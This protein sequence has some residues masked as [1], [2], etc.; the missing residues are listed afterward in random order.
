MR[1]TEKEAPNE[2]VRSTFMGDLP[3]AAKWSFKGGNSLSEQSVQSDCP[4]K[5]PRLTDMASCVLSLHFRDVECSCVAKDVAGK[6][7]RRGTSPATRASAM[8]DNVS[9]LLC[10]KLGAVGLTALG[11]A[12]LCPAVAGGALLRLSLPGPRLSLRA[13]CPYGAHLVNVTTV[14]AAPR[15]TQAFTAR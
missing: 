2:K 6:A 1:C 10:Q 12:Q 14:G 5:R 9:S 13:I 11:R 7:L 4:V 3:S 15:S 8:P